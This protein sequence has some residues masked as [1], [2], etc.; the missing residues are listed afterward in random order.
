MKIMTL[1]G[2]RPPKDGTILLHQGP[3]SLHSLQSGKGHSSAKRAKKSPSK[4]LKSESSHHASPI[5]KSSVAPSVSKLPETASPH[6]PK[7]HSSSTQSKSSI[8][9]WDRLIRLM[10]G[11]HDHISGLA[12]VMYSHNNNVQLRLTTIKT[13]LDEIQRKLEE[14]LQQFVPKRGRTL[15]VNTMTI[16]QSK[17]ENTYYEYYD[18]NIE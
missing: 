11:L 4:P 15:T 14:N 9:H 6:T 17:W 18:Y 13:Q 10:K 3:I 7:P 12:N 8:L 2:I 16:A 1:K 5:R